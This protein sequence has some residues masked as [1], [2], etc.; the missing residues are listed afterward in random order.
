VSLNPDKFTEWCVVARW[1]WL[2]R[3][4][5]SAQIREGQSKLG[6]FP[7]NRLGVIPIPLCCR[8]TW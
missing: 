6:Q 5:D 1:L 8:L 4:S 7:A 3:V 2:S